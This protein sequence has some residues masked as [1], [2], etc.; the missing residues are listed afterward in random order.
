MNTNKFQEIAEVVDFA[1]D[2]QQ[3][4]A[5]VRED[6]KVDFKDALILPSLVMSGK[7]AFTGLN[8]IAIADVRAEMPRLIEHLRERFDLADHELELL[9]E[10]SVAALFSL[11]SVGE[12]WK[13][14]FNAK[15]QAQEQQ[16]VVVAA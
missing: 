14:Y 15:Q 5:K 4:I 2:L 12:R 7:R 10:D 13:A 16:T 11:L 8:G 3:S 9:I 1:I 6:D